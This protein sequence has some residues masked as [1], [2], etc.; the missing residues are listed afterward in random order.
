MPS[1]VAAMRA[2]F[3]SVRRTRPSKVRRST[4]RMSAS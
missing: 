4:S 2:P 1:K 3:H